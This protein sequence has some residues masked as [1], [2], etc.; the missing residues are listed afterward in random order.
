[1]INRDLNHSLNRL[2]RWS[3]LIDSDRKS[4]CLNILENFDAQTRDIAMISSLAEALA[5]SGEKWSWPEGVSPIC[6]VI[7]T[8]G[9]SSLSTLVCT[10]IL[11]ACGIYVPNVTV[12]GSLAGAVDVLALINGYRTNLYHS[13]IQEVFN[14]SKISRTFTSSSMAPADGYL[15]RMRSEVGKKSVPSLV[16]ASLLAKKIAIANSSCAVDIRCGALGNLGTTLDECKDNAELFVQVADKIGISVRCV[17]TDVDSPQTPFFGRG[18]SL[19]A[20]ES[21]LTRNV[22]NAW[23]SKHLETCLRISGEALLACGVEDSVDQAQKTVTEALQNGSAFEAF[24]NNLISQGSSES[25]MTQAV[26]EFRMENRVQVQSQYSGFVS[27]IDTK[28]LADIVVFANRGGGENSNLLGL[29]CLKEC[30]DSIKKGEAI[31]VIRHNKHVGQTVISQVSKAII[32]AYK[33]GTNFAA[34]SPPQVLAFV[35]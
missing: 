10:Y 21:V 19:A 27:G 31:A 5:F 17:I 22:E 3:E 29:E 26:S 4:T 30:G 33:I 15:F 20:L 7:S 1:M 8:G 11:G 2:S 34:A 25:N 14:R 12:P 6:D 16:I 23:L 32:S 18:E 28:I 13:E 24:H 9:P 35:N